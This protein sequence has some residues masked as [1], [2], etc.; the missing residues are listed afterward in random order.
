MTLLLTYLLIVILAI[1]AAYHLRGIIRAEEAKLV[2]L[3]VI[4]PSSLK[5]GQAPL[6]KGSIPLPD[7]EL[8]EELY[9][10]LQKQRVPFSIEAVVQSVGEEISFY[11]SVNKKYQK[12]VT[13]LIK[14][15]W[16]TAYVDEAD[17]YEPWAT[18]DEAGSEATILTTVTLSKP[19]GLP[20]KTRSTT[21]HN[22]DSFAPVLE[23]LAKLKTVGESAIIQWIVRPANPG[24]LRDL[25]TV[26]ASLEQGDYKTNN[27]IHN[28]FLLTK[29][30]LPILKEKVGSPLLAANCHILVHAQSE[31]RAEQITNE[32]TQALCDLSSGDNYNQLQANQP[33]NQTNAVT[34]F[35][36]HRF[37][38]SNELII[39]ARELAGAFHLSGFSPR[40]ASAKRGQTP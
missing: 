17:S 1:L 9:K 13:Q 5:R 2:P 18:I 16:P 15:L 23:C 27:H 8:S 25:G 7:Q 3:L 31:S 28:Q 26:I 11:L 30:N 21:R 6:S 10:R 4:I 32:L 37:I 34:T 35:L 24:L 33:K 20:L 39:S 19:Y 40:L 38:E 36:D 12:K 22:Q 29:H 14:S